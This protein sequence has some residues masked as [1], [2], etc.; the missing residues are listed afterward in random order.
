M[1]VRALLLDADRLGLAELLERDVLQLEAEV[2]ADELAAG[3]DGDV[4]E[5]GLA[6]VAEAGGLDRADVAGRRG[7]C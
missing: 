3:Q 6:A 1:I 5:H 2:L 7:A 4:A